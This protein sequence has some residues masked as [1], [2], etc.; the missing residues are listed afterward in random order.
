MKRL[1]WALALVLAGCASQTDAVSEVPKPSEAP[2]TA[3]VPDGRKRLVL[4]VR[5]ARDIFVLKADGTPFRDARNGYKGEISVEPYT[6]R[7]DLSALSVTRGGA[8]RHSLVVEL[9]YTDAQHNVSDDRPAVF[10]EVDGRTLRDGVAVDSVIQTVARG[11]QKATRIAFALLEEGLAQIQQAKERVGI[12][13]RLKSDILAA[14]GECER[15][16]P[17]SAAAQ[18]CRKPYTGRTI[19]GQGLAQLKTFLAG[20]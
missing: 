6:S 5:S 7:L 15:A 16:A 3:T 18:D 20:G 10:L 14:A 17:G 9:P 1:L 2:P 13:V 4:P 11:E 12:K 8:T 19:E